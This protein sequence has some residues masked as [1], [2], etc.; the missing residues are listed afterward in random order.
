[1]AYEIA[2]AIVPTIERMF[3]LE[4]NVLRHLTVL[5]PQ[6]LRDYRAARVAYAA[7]QAA[8]AA[9]EKQGE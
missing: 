5:L 6:K 8:K 3:T 4:E 7:A 1:M 9:A 2:P